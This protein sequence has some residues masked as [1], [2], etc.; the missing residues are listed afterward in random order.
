MCMTTIFY[1]FQFA[2]KYGNVLSVRIFGARFVVLNGYK[3]VK[4]VYLQQGENFADRP[5][6]PLI[7]DILGDNGE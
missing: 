2:E 7:Y 1:T 4:Q 6:I 5:H 3:Q